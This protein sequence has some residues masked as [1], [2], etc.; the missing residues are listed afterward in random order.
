M[1]YKENIHVYLMF[2][3][4]VFTQKQKEIELLLSVTVIVS[5]LLH[6]IQ[7]YIAPEMLCIFML[8]LPPFSSS[9]QHVKQHHGWLGT[10]FLCLTYQRIQSFQTFL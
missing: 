8:F 10:I 3:L 6:T 7:L 2:T 9:V 1:L 5:L 4:H